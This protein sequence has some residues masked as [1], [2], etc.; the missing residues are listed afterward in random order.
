MRQRRSDAET[1]PLRDPR[2]YQYELDLA[3]IAEVWRRGS[4][5]SSWLLDLTAKA[6]V[7][8]PALDDYFGQIAD[9]GEGRWTVQ[10]AIDEGVSAQ[11]IA[12]ALFERFSSRDGADFQ[13]RVVSAMRHSCFGLPTYLGMIAPGVPSNPWTPSGYHLATSAGESVSVCLPMAS[14]MAMPLRQPAMRSRVSR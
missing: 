3:A 5:I 14:P 9:S 7:A 4:V 10:A 12:T 6:L 1:A 8:Q 11:T 13:D 2:Y